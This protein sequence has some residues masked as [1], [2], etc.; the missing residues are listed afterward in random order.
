[1]TLDELYDLLD[2]ARSHESQLGE[3]EICGA[4]GHNVSLPGDYHATL[5][6]GHYVKLLNASGSWEEKKAWTRAR[7]QIAADGLRLC[8]DRTD[9][10]AKEAILNFGKFAE[11]EKRVYNKFRKTIDEMIAHKNEPLPTPDICEICGKPGQSLILDGSYEATL[12]AHHRREF[13]HQALSSDGKFAQKYAEFMWVADVIKRRD[14]SQV[15]TLLN[16]CDEM[17]DIMTTMHTNA[18]K[19]ITDNTQK[20]SRKAEN[21]R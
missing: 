6:E 15:N 5:C 12:C 8:D 3:C 13:D 20:G 4:I 17:S 16:L 11:V 10:V 9:A 14:Y 1:M 19:W 18:A 2:L 21:V 7:L